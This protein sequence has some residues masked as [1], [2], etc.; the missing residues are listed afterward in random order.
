MIMSG[1]R[2]FTDREVISLVEEVFRYYRVVRVFKSE[3][4]RYFRLFK[5]LSEDEVGELL[6]RA[7]DLGVINIGVDLRGGRPEIVIWRPEDIDDI[8]KKELEDILRRERRI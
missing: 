7:E 1:K 3:F 2:R 5:G 6:M 8:P 4:M